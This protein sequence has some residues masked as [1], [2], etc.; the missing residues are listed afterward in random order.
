MKPIYFFILII[1]TVSFTGSGIIPCSNFRTGKFRLHS[2]YTGNNYIFDRRDSFQ[3]ETGANGHKSKWRINW[4]RDCEYR[5]TYQDQIPDKNGDT[6]QFIFKVLNFQII[7][8]AKRYYIYSCTLPGK[9]TA[10]VD[11]VWKL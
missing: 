1:F 4:L 3:L 8:T 10:L 7:E 11:T 2:R 6:L 5:L 9:E